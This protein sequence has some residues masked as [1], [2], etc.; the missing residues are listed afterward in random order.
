[1]TTT[2]SPS[3]LNTSIKEGVGSSSW[4]DSLA[5]SLIETFTTDSDNLCP[6]LIAWLISAPSMTLEDLQAQLPDF[7]LDAI[8]IANFPEISS[9]FQNLTN[10]FGGSKESKAWFAKT[11]FQVGR[12]ALAANLTKKHAVILIPGII[13]TG[14]E[15]WSTDEYTA[16]YFRK[17]VWGTSSMVSAIVTNKDRWIRA[18]SLDPETGLDPPGA[19]LRSAQGFSAADY[20]IQGYYLWSKILE[21]L[22]VLGYDGHDLALAAYDWRLS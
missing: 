3:K 18:M 21:N 8:S 6:A 20:F 1:M 14:L 7:H 5:V 11:D 22:A 13:S 9:V 16:S 17:R 4:E 12:N 15:S 19:K 10:Q 2:A